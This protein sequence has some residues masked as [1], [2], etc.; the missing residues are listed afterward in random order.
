MRRVCSHSNYPSTENCWL[1]IQEELA[2]RQAVLFNSRLQFCQLVKYRESVSFTRTSSIVLTVIYVVWIPSGHR[3]RGPQGRAKT[4]IRALL[5][6]V[7]YRHWTQ[8]VFALDSHIF[9]CGNNNL[10]SPAAAA[11]ICPLHNS[12]ML[13]V[14]TLRCAPA[15]SRFSRWLCPVCALNLA[16]KPVT[17]SHYSQ[18]VHGNDVGAFFP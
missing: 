8:E 1:A 4:H 17:N 15:F 18:P 11:L 5:F 6:S 14:W 16:E 12:A 10:F 9:K 7:T 3:F 13:W 2:T